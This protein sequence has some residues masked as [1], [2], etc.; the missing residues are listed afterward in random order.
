MWGFRREVGLYEPDPDSAKVGLQNNAAWCAACA[1][2]TMSKFRLLIALSM[3]FTTF[4][5]CAAKKRVQTLEE[6]LRNCRA[7][8]QS[9]QGATD[10]QTPTGTTVAVAE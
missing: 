10:T 7:E 3:T 1:G 6:E 9:L 5:G 4:T 2:G 8:K